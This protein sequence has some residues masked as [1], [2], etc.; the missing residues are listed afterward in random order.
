MSMILHNSCFSFFRG[1]DRIVE[2]RLSGQYAL[3]FRHPITHDGR[4]LQMT[5]MLFYRRLD[6]VLATALEVIGIASLTRPLPYPIRI[7][8]NLLVWPEAGFARQSVSS[9]QDFFLQMLQQVYGPKMTDRLDSDYTVCVDAHLLDAKSQQQLAASIQRSSA[10]CL[11]ILPPGVKTPAAFIP[12]VRR[13]LE[14]YVSPSPSPLVAADIEE[15]FIHRG[16]HTVTLTGAGPRL[17]PSVIAA[18]DILLDQTDFTGFVPYTDRQRY[19]SEHTCVF[20]PHFAADWFVR[21]GNLESITLNYLQSMG[22]LTDPVPGQ[23]TLDGGFAA[24]PYMEPVT[25]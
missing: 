16:I 4:R 6:V 7:P 5:S 25:S 14:V 11:L 20:E 10:H 22:F 2:E 19:A 24:K 1:G 13:Q 12:L 23:Y 8:Q 3:L 18:A 9:A 21:P 15:I 17:F